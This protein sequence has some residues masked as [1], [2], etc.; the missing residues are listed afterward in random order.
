MGSIRRWWLILSVLALVAAARGSDGEPDQAAVD[1]AVDDIT[2]DESEPEPEAEPGSRIEVVEA[3]LILHHYP[4]ETFAPNPYWAQVIVKAPAVPGDAVVEGMPSDGQ[5]LFAYSIIAD[6]EFIPADFEGGF[7]YQWGIPAPGEY[8][9]D[10]VTVNGEDM[11]AVVTEALGGATSF[12]AQGADV[13]D[14]ELMPTACQLPYV[15]MV[16]I[17]AAAPSRVPVAQVAPVAAGA[18]WV[19]QRL[20]NATMSSGRSS[21]LVMRRAPCGGPLR[22]SRP[23]LRSTTGS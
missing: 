8:P 12:T 4:N 13:R 21:S 16:D 10:H 3:C 1:A 15:S 22:R 19:D 14:E 18:W 20:Q 2:E 11:T 6:G 5:E 7:G 23:G 17:Q 9:I